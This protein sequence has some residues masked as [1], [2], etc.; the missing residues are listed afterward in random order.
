[1]GIRIGILDSGIMVQHPA[2]QNFENKGYSLII[3][4][5]GNVEV[6][7][8]LSDDIGHGTAV[9]YLLQNALY[10]TDPEIKAEVINIKIHHVGVPLELD[11]F[12]KILEFIYKNEQ[13]DFLNISCGIVRCGNISKLQ[14]ICNRFAESGCTLVA[15]YD[16][17]GA[18]SFPA[19]LNNVIGV[20]S[21][22]EL[23]NER[24]MDAGIVDVFVKSKY[25]RVPWID[26][27]MTLVKGNSFAC[28]L[29]TAEL[30]I[31]KECGEYIIKSRDK[32]SCLIGNNK[33]LP[34]MYKSVVIPFNKEIHAIANNEEL[35]DTEIVAYY[36]HKSTGQVG[37]RICD[38]IKWS[39]NEKRIC[40]I[41]NID[42]KAF[43]SIIL[44]HMDELDRL[45]RANLKAR[46]L[47]EAR[48]N[49]KTVYSFDPI[50]NDGYSSGFFVPQID[51]HEVVNN[52]GKLYKSDKPI[53]SVVG[54]SSRQGKFT[55]QLI[56]RKKLQELGYLVGQ[57]GTEP[58][59]LLFGMDCVFPCG[60]NST[61]NLTIYNTIARINQ[62]IFYLS[63]NETDIIL[64]GSQNAV[65]TYNDNN[66]NNYPLYHQ[67]VLQGIQPDAL[68]LCINP[69]D[70]I[71]YIKKTILAAESLTDG[72]VIAI[73]CFPY[74][75]NETWSVFQNSKQRISIQKALWLKEACL[76]ELQINMYMLDNE[77]DQNELINDIIS[78]FGSEENR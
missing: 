19:A 36:T 58:S 17:E 28:A 73:V 27:K 21:S 35:I 42:W 63:Q 3:N 64:T 62:M 39:T 26:G 16:N 8:C 55:L 11:E 7:N 31:K 37:R 52:Y 24:F 50:N 44:G 60:Y 32:R 71:D 75:I 38:I 77:S 76:N 18:I 47:E 70:T 57:L 46:I 61:V 5:T 68:V 1:M 43:D 29:V 14:N 74:D 45:T 23:D 40:N 59:A 15:A 48:I 78:F 67:I 2:L 56:L 10:N 12:V 30:A 65:I 41:D 69:Y 13:F 33:R 22:I 20:D 54:T 66:I 6:N 25:L 49:G 53:L 72:K 4:E 34:K 9:Y 51:N